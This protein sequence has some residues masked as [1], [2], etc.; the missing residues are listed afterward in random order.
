MIDCL[1]GSELDLIVIKVDVSIL[2]GIL[3]LLIALVVFEEFRIFLCIGILNNSSCLRFPLEFLFIELLD[4]QIHLLFAFEL[5][6]SCIRIIFKRVRNQFFFKYQRN[7]IVPSK[8]SA[9]ITCFR[10]LEW[11][12]NSEKQNINKN[13]NLIDQIIRIFS[14]PFPHPECFFKLYLLSR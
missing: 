2:I 11:V 14:C 1:R 12:G 4:F 9:H 7:F 10:C 3:S 5:R 13:G 8:P 6:I